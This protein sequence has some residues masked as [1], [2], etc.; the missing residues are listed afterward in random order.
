MSFPWSF[1]LRWLRARFPRHMFMVPLLEEWERERPQ[2]THFVTL[3]G[4]MILH[5]E[6]HRR[7]VEQCERAGAKGALAMLLPVEPV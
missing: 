2:L 1:Y 6:N 4:G 5:A 3:P 7:L